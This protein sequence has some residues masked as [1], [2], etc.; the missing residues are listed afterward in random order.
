MDDLAATL[1]L[2]GSAVAVLD[3]YYLDHFWVDQ[4]RTHAL[5]SVVLRDFDSDVGSLRLTDPGDVVAFDGRVLLETLRPALAREDMGQSWMVIGSRADHNPVPHPPWAAM[6]EELVGR[7]GRALSGLELTESLCEGLVTLFSGD[8]RAGHGAW[9]DVPTLQHGLW[10]YHHTL[11]WFGRFLG[12]FEH[13]VSPNATLIN[14]AAQDL[15]VVR[16]LLRHAGV[17]EQDRMVRHRT[18]VTRRLERI[19]RSLE[20]VAAE[21][22]SGAGQTRQESS[23]QGEIRA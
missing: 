15:L 19:A 23:M 6:K 7:G 5:H 4:G 2:T 20:T 3:T 10:A 18:E 12:I 1:A 21:L 14:G 22:P 9:S 16:A 11:R 13:N 17:E 8:T